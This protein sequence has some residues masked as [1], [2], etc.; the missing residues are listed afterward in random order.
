MRWVVGDVHGCAVALELLLE[1]IRF[2]PASDELWSVGDLVNTGPDSVGVLR[3]WRAT[4]GR[5]VLGNHDVH[6]LRVKAG[7]RELRQEDRL[8]D[9]LAAEDSTELLAA[10]RS[11][12]VLARLPESRQVR[13]AW[14]VHAG[15]HPGWTDLPAAARRL[16]ALPR[17]DAGLRDPELAFATRVRC[18]LPG[19]ERLSFAG[20]PRDCP[21]PYR[22][23]DAFYRGEALVVHG[24]WAMRGHYR[25]E[26]TLG[27]DSGRVYG[28]PLTAWCQEEDRIV[29]VR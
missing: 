13:E 12:P 15:L 19:G 1:A 7:Q 26:R 29:Q 23:W 10:L 2:D 14:L 6:A 8:D 24:H 17:S 5:G 22:P 3:L 28:G 9:L 18:C 27:L 21:A 20:P 16:N 11:L 4:G 25:G